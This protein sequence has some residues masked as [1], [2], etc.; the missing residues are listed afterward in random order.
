M[1]ILEQY[2]EVQE[3]LQMVSLAKRDEELFLP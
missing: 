3:K 2:P 1:E